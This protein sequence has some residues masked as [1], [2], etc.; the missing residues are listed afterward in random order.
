MSLP[1]LLALPSA[2]CSFGNDAV[3]APGYPGTSSLV[4]RSMSPFWCRDSLTSAITS[5]D[6]SNPLTHW[7]QMVLQ[8]PKP[9]PRLK[10]MSKA[11]IGQGEHPQ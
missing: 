4:S 7:G 6:M 9:D 5:A 11:S 1:A 3:K 8:N 2:H 10:F